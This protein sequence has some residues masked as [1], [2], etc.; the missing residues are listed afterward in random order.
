MSLNSFLTKLGGMIKAQFQEKQIDATSQVSNPFKGTID[1]SIFAG[2]DIDTFKDTIAKG[3]NLSSD[4]S[5]FYQNVNEAG[6]EDMFDY[7]DKNSDGIIDEEELNEASS[8]DGEE[9]TISGYDLNYAINS[10]AYESIMDSFDGQ[11]KAG[12]IDAQQANNE[13]MQNYTSNIGGSNYQNYG[14]Q[15]QN[16][17]T[18]SSEKQYSDKE[19]LETIEN[20][21]IPE[22]EK[23]KEEIINKANEDIEKKNSELDNL[24]KEN[25]EKLGELGEK[26]SDKQKE[27]QE[28]DKNI[29]EYDSQIS[30]KQSEIGK[31][32]S[33]LSNLEAELGAIKTDTDD[34]EI[35]KSNTE[36][37]SE[38]EK[39]IKEL[40]DK[41]KK[42]EEEISELEDKKEQENKLKTQN[43]S[44]LEE[45]QAQIAE[46][47]P[48]IAQKMSEI[49]EEIQNIEET[50]NKDVAE[51]DE[52]IQA[53]RTEANELQ[54][55]IGQKTGEA[56]SM[57]GSK[58]VQ[59]ALRLAEEE[60]A[61]GVYEFTGN[62]DNP[63][64]DKYRNGAA[65]GQPWCASFV[66]W[67]Y[68]AGQNSDNAATF[69]YDASVAGIRNKAESA[70][71]Y[72]QK[73]SY[74]P[75]A[76]DLMIQQNN[77]SHVGMVTSVDPDGTIH[78]IE[79]NSSDKVQRCTYA[80][81]SS[82]YNKISGWV[83][84]NEWLSN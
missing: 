26:Y 80:P 1:A 79:G 35:N 3:M 18:I 38:L 32:E 46:K 53:K 62:N 5:I 77:A 12:K 11:V 66:S 81:G 45:I 41:N 16:G 61:K 30:K 24:I 73:G 2:A 28:N 17:S 19:K 76:G 22:L 58:M 71:Y 83:K 49:Q 39:Q 31:N 59:D 51:I 68:G 57:T 6:V 37:K 84:M 55:E 27:I 9:G 42:L 52:K 25:E 78:T 75:Q 36:R 74:T 4:D 34:D 43:R 10:V 48:E 50:K 54:K 20:K 60:L 13:A 23:Q 47:N 8:V 21:E 65:N 63:E 29:N 44:E 70:G 82:G 64:I 69:G 67:I 7:F 72:A 14:S 40:K 15:T 56:E 33:T